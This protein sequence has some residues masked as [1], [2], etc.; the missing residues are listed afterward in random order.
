MDQVIT[1][2]IPTQTATVSSQPKYASFGR[3]FLARCIDVIILMLLAFVAN[4]PVSVGLFLLL[5]SPAAK[6][7]ESMMAL[8]IMLAYLIAPI[9]SLT[10]AIL[11]YRHYWVKRGGQTPGAKMLA[12]KV[13]KEDGSA[14][15]FG[16]MLAR[17]LSNFLSSIVFYLG[18]LW[19]LWDDK[20]QCWHDK[21]A[22]TIVV[23]TDQKPRTAVASG[24]VGCTCL[25]VILFYIVIIASAVGGGF[26]SSYMKNSSSSSQ[27]SSSPSATSNNTVT[28]E[29]QNDA[30]IYAND[31]FGVV[32]NYRVSKGLVA[33]AEDSKLCAYAQRRLEQLATLGRIDDH[34]GFYED[35]S[36]SSIAPAYFDTVHTYGEIT[37]SVS[38]VENKPASP[39]LDTWITGQNLDST[40]IVSACVRATPQFMVF[41]TEQTK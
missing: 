33:L 25:S 23:E 6:S 18:Y 3:R 15:D 19:M 8:S 34:K 39:A 36:N 13:T 38:S 4:V 35:M 1:S 29:T 37:N 11:F 2:E 5:M 28:V 27:S 24:L 30:Y 20:K 17:Y 31:I 41:I 32:N 22:K 21:I 7:N 14:L 12:I 26:L 9:L 40:K 10:I 16:S